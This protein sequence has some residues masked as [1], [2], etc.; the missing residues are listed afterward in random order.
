MKW[1]KKKGKEECWGNENEEIVESRG[2]PTKFRFYVQIPHGDL[3]SWPP[4]LGLITVYL[5][6]TRTSVFIK[7]GSSYLECESHNM[8]IK[9]LCHLRALICIGI[10][11]S[12]VFYLDWQ[13]LRLVNSPP[14][15]VL[16]SWEALN[17]LCFL[18]DGSKAFNLCSDSHLFAPY[19]FPVLFALRISSSL[20][21]KHDQCLSILPNLRNWMWHGRI[22]CLD[23]K[24]A[25]HI[26][27]K[28][29]S[30]Y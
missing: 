2:K 24:V 16:F 5:F 15:T 18:R 14:Q 7:S 26:S 11:L 1:I 23:L 25:S 30:W 8:F 4:H 20:V 21:N 13:L 9:S 27:E 3:N 10:N 6:F 12:H 19:R 17:L 22:A 29:V 28:T